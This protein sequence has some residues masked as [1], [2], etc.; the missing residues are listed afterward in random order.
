M[1]ASTFDSREAYHRLREGGMDEPA[2]D[3]VVEIL[4]PFVTRD[5]LQA[6]LA[7]VQLRMIS[8]NVAIATIA[9]AVVALVD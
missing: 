2:S 4:N 7:K 6:E 1:A 8:F 5:I 3:A 9:V